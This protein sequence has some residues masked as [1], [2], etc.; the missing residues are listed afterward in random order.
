MFNT[1]AQ[2]D[3]EYELNARYD[4]VREAYAA[5]A[6]DPYEEGYSDYL[7]HCEAD[8]VAPLEFAAW[9]AGLR[10]PRAAGVAQLGSWSTD[11]FDEVP[12]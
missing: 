7:F 4:Y 6:L 10:Q 9:K 3:A 11:S 12:F 1:Q 8:G 5:T 2:E